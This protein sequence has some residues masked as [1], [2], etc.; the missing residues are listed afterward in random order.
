M[1]DVIRKVGAVAAAN[2]ATRVTHVRVRLGA[3]SHFTAGHFRGHFADAARGTI[4]EGAEVDAVVD[5]DPTDVHARDV[6]LESVSVEAP[7]AEEVRRRCARPAS[8]G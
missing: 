5:V 8:L 1:A 7:S 6:V 4:A 3:L 2:D